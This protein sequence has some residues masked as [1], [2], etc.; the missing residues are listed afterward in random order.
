MKKMIDYI[1]SKGRFLS[2][3]E[4]I[5]NAFWFVTS[6]ILSLINLSVKFNNK[7]IPVN[8]YGITLAGSGSGKSFVYEQIKSY[9]KDIIEKWDDALLF[10]FRQNTKKEDSIF[11]DGNSLKIESFL[12][13][14]EVSIEGTKEGLYLRAL[15]LSY[16]FVGSLNII[17]EEILDIM[18]NSTIDTLKELYDGRFIGKVIKANINENLYGIRA[19]ALLFGSSIALKRDSK[20]YELFNKSLSSG[21]YR[22]SFIYYEEPK[23]IKLNNLG[24]VDEPDYKDAVFDVLKANRESLSTGIPYILEVDK[25]AIEVLLDIN[26]ELIEFSN[27]HKEETRMSAEIGSFDKILKLSCLYSVVNKK[28][29]VYVEDVEYAYDFYKRCRET[30]FSLFNVEPQH[31][32]IYKILKQNN[33]LTKSEI[34]EKDIFNRLTF[35]ED[36]KLVEEL[37]YRNNERLVVKGSKIKFYSIEKLPIN[38]LDKCIVSIPKIDKREK[39]TE[40]ISME[41]PFFGE[42]QSIER[43]VKSD[44]VSNFCLVHFEN[45]KRKADKAIEGQNVIGIDVDNGVSIN[46]ILDILNNYVYLIYTTKSHQKDK[47][48]IVCDRFRI[49]LPTKT[50]FYVDNEQ[51]KQL[52]SNICDALGVGSYDVS[53]RNI[54]RLWFTN[55]SAMIFKNQQGE[56]FDVVP[57]LPDTDIRDVIEKQIEKFDESD[58][59]IDEINRRIGGMIKWFINNTYPSVRNQN[60]FRLGSFIGDLTGSYERIEK[61]L[62]KAN[63]MLLEPVS[64]KELRKTV[65]ASLKRKYS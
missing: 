29:K 23:D 50:K 54:D 51:H 8:Y 6:S 16:C 32:R 52:I 37:C 14:F 24:Y 40:Y 45:G 13:P 38:N 42:G 15:S 58:Y 18:S 33:R 61:E 21:I 10:S 64:E 20:T 17:N 25:N 30:N 35:N 34:L 9:Y 7:I 27:K 36:I 63:S 57:Y 19:N 11:I 44:K 59:D 22:R 56:L 62:Y 53:T 12:P 26:N 5:E 46:E 4:I 2:S 28:D 1:N 3:D 43:L 31:K 55:P 47:G 65:L 60:L 49:L 39:T 41:I 48:G